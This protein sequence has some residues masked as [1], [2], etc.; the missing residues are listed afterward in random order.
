MRTGSC[1]GASATRSSRFRAARSWFTP[2]PTRI[3][4]STRRAA[5]R[6]SWP[7]S[8]AAVSAAWRTGWSASPRRSPAAPRSR[9]AS[10]SSRTRCGS[11]SSA[12]SALPCRPTTC[13]G[14]RPLCSCRRTSWSGGLG[15][16]DRP[17]VPVLVGPT[18]VGKT[19]VAAA[20]GD[21]APITVISADAR[22]VYRGLDIGTAKPPRE[23]QRRVPHLGLDLV[24][25]GERY[26]AGRF[27]RDATGWLASVRAGGREPVVVGG[28]GFYVRAL[29][30]GLFREPPLDAARRERLRTW[31]EQLPVT[32]LA[33]WAA[34][35][36]RPVA[37]GPRQRAARA[38]EVALLSG[39]TLSWGQREARETGIMRPGDIHL[40]RPR[41]ALHPRIGERG[42]QVLRAGPVAAVRGR[43]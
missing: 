17:L 24:E 35:L 20:L 42:D 26:S 5:C 9:P 16:P 40:T 39:R 37:G 1:C 22:Q 30:E 18:G 2:R 14:G 29:A 3:R 15:E 25:P 12:S 19:A 43:L 13:T 8:R 21:R 36:D 41:D 7:I 6:S 4:G 23:L 33:H 11:S 38:I 31:G 10:G 34:R 27:A 28:T 32:R